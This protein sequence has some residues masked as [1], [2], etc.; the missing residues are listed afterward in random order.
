MTLDTS[1]LATPYLTRV[2]I[3]KVA[4]RDRVLEISDKL[5]LDARKS[6]IE[7]VLCEFDMAE[8]TVARVRH[9]APVS[10]IKLVCWDILNQGFDEWTDKQGVVLD[11][12][13][14]ASTLA[15]RRDTKYRQPFV[16]KIDNGVGE[17]VAGDKVQMVEVKESLTLLLPEFD[18]RVLAQSVLD[19]I[20]DW[21][22]VNFRRRQDAQAITLP[23]PQG[24]AL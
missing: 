18:S 6:R 14:K 10:A 21:E 9:Y 5:S 22:I 11:D 13:V 4:T 23:L 12:D 7:F 15:I 2:Q 19:Y 17:E 20:R 1:A 16:L 3:H 24:E 8:K